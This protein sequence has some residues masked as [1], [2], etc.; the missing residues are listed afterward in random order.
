VSPLHGG[1]FNYPGSCGTLKE[2]HRHERRNDGLPW[3]NG[4]L[5]GETFCKIAIGKGDANQKKQVC[6]SF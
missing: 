4:R 3:L 2:R 6:S 5:L 1:P